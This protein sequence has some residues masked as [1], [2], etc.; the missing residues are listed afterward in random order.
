MQHPVSIISVYTFV[1]RY[2]SAVPTPLTFHLICH[3]HWDR[4]WYLPQSA[5][6]AR[7]LPALTATLDG[8]SAEP[9]A[10]FLLDGQT[11]LIED[12]LAIDERLRTR[13]RH[14]VR[15]GQLETGPW[16][17]LADELIPSGESLV[18]NLLEGSADA[19]ALGR[20]MPVLYSPDA[21]GH[22]ASLPSIAAEFGLAWGALWR[23]L[24]PTA[25]DQDLYRWIAPDGQ[26]LLV[27]HFP[28]DGYEFGVGLSPDAPDLRDRWS[29][30]RRRAVDRAVTT[31]I[32]IF[33]GADHHGP[34]DRPAVLRDALQHLEPGAIVRLSSLGEYMAAAAPEAGVAPIRQ[35]ELRTPGHTWV[36]QGVH[37]TRARLK[38]LHASAELRLQRHV[39]PLLAIAR[40]RCGADH[41]P[42]LRHA[43]RTLLAC[44]FHD[45]LAGCCHDD[46][47]REQRVR[48]AAVGALS[49]ELST[50]AI[51][52]LTG[53]DADRSREHPRTAR[54][55]LT[56]WN[57]AARRRTGVVVATVTGFLGDVLVGPPGARQP[58]SGAGYRALSLRSGD[59]ALV[60]V[61]ILARRNALER[62][63]APRHYPDQDDVE[64]VD[65]A[66]RGT[67]VPGLGF[68]TFVPDLADVVPDPSALVATAARLANE[69][70]EVHVGGDGRIDLLD[71]RSGERYRDI[72]RL[73]T[74]PDH[75]DSYT[76]WPGD[77]SPDD[78]VTLM[79]RTVMASGP[80]VAVLA[81]HLRLSRAASA[82]LDACISIFLHEGSP[83]VRLRIDMDN[84]WRD[85]RMQLGFPVGA[86]D[87][88]TAGSSFGVVRRAAIERDPGSWRAEAPLATAPAQRYVAAGDTGRGLAILS[89]GFVEYEWTGERVIRI[90]ALRGVAQ[91]SRNSLPTRPGHAGWPTAI[92]DAQE[93]GPHRIELAVLPVTAGDIE[94]PGM[95][96]ASWEEAFLPLWGSWNRSFV[97]NAAQ[98]ADAGFE[99][100]G[101]G[102]VFTACK[103]AIASGGVVLRCVNLSGATVAARWRSRTPLRRALL[104]RADETTI[105]PLPVVDETMIHFTAAPGALITIGVESRLSHDS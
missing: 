45:T 20:R 8:L 60:P 42:L 81:V 70:V 19:A 89:A 61:Q 35:G 71:R 84:S 49:S 92:P 53:H 26:S 41:S 37:S 23:G 66:F 50:T 52:Q 25:E 58:E 12:V 31:Q 44:Q 105:R 94:R 56:V 100:D 32:A 74:R 86:G 78:T 63:D 54:P 97:G 4:E 64:S 65:L 40:L 3:T 82:P 46:V 77:P 30:L 104:L 75:G 33:V 28:R 13:L 72:C 96:D 22:P 102:L 21:F 76:P 68:S 38:R 7:L 36:L 29:A 88:V 62:S 39:E 103:P 85:H 67:D 83:L 17:V 24:N 79:A 80:L 59:G 101:D 34:L 51:H 48:L 99:L 18:R 73:L 6:T 91:L 27:Y 14:A 10:R 69:H 95:L 5:F 15:N 2:V 9:D 43:T 87:S 11:I 55:T 16:Y 90:T 93:L 47:A 57:P 98:L 1:A